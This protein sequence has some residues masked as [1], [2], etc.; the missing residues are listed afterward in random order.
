MYDE[1]LIMKQKKREAW[2]GSPEYMD[3]A[4]LYMRRREEPYVSW[5]FLSDPKKEQFTK[6]VKMYYDTH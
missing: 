6:K 5:N 4:D 3:A 1:Y 2:E